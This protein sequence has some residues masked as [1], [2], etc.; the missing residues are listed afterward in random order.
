MWTDG[1]LFKWCIYTSLSL[2]ELTQ[3][4]SEIDVYMF[5]DYR[6]FHDSNLTKIWLAGVFVTGLKSIEFMKN[7]LIVASWHHMDLG[8]HW[9]Q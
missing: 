8:Q 3:N 9:L 7:Q 2:N 5:I 4:F 1:G 6:Y